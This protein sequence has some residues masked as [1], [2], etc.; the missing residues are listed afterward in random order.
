MLFPNARICT[1]HLNNEPTQPLQR[2][3]YVFGNTF[4]VFFFKA[5]IYKPSRCRYYV[6]LHPR[7]DA[8]RPRLAHPIT[9]IK[10]THIKPFGRPTDH[11]LSRAHLPQGFSFPPSPMVHTTIWLIGQVCVFVICIHSPVQPLGGSE[12]YYLYYCFSF[13]IAED[14]HPPPSPPSHTTSR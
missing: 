14:R 6:H 4:A 9:V 11:R 13:D 3:E 5:D 2:C 10:K 7:S 8:Q 1:T 12:H